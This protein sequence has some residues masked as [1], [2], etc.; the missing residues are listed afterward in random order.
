MRMAGHEERI[1]GMDH[2]RHAPA[3]PQWARW[4]TRRWRGRGDEG[5][6]PPI[7]ANEEK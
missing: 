2:E 5:E 6:T 7:K 3:K 1:L 4:H